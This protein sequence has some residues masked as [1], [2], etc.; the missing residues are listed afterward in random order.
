M[1]ETTRRLFE[2]IHAR[3]NHRMYLQSDPLRYVYRYD[4]PEDREIVALLAAL[5]AYGR[6]ASIFQFLDRLLARLG[7]NPSETLRKKQVRGSNLY[8]RFQTERDTERLLAVLG[9]WLKEKSFP[10]MVRPV[11]H[12]IYDAIDTLTEELTQSIP[13]SARTQGWKFLVGKPEVPSVAKRWCLFFRWM[14]RREPPDTGLYAMLRPDILIYPLDTHIL[15]IARWQSLTTRRTSTRQTAREIT[16]S[17]RNLS[18]SDPLRYDFALT[19]PGI[20]NDRELLIRLRHSPLEFQ[21]AF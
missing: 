6:V 21:A 17:F 15:R 19:R 11:F 13:A 4:N 10:V 14:V 3:Y 5:F 16:A 18:Q 8:Y 1:H 12:D 20:L 2:E 9:E 7:P